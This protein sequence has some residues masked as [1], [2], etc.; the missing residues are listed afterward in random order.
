MLEITLRMSKIYQRLE[1]YSRQRCY[2]YGATDV[3]TC[4]VASELLDKISNK[5]ELSD[6][7][8]LKLV[9]PIVLPKT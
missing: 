1:C 7:I 6:K 5:I 3:C 4:S 9:K 2:G 8:C